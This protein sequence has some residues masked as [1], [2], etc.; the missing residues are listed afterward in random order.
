[1]KISRLPEHEVRFEMIAMMDIV[2]QLIAF[3][4]IVSTFIVREKIEVELPVAANSAL[5][6]N[7]QHRV[8]ISI[9]ADG[10]IWLGAKAVSVEALAGELA[11]LRSADAAT[12]VVIRSDRTSAY[13]LVKQVMKICRDAGLSDLIFAS[14]QSGS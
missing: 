4:M 7:Q 3:F 13:A 5:A 1:M 10:T 14:Y 8:A 11:T 12:R 2:F 9:T 6:E